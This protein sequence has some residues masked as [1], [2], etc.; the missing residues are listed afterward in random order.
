MSKTVLLL[1]GGLSAE[2]E[3]S[4]TSGAPVQRALEASGYRVIPFDPD[5]DV[6]PSCPVL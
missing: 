1:Q 2:R 6:G 4:L 3:V 5:W